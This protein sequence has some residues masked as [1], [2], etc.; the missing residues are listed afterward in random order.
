MKTIEESIRLFTNAAVKVTYED[1]S[2]HIHNLT[3][4]K[5]IK[6]SYQTSLII[7]SF[8]SG[9]TIEESYDDIKNYIDV[10]KEEFALVVSTLL[11]SEFIVHPDN[12]EHKWADEIIKKWSKYGWRGASLYHLLTYDY[13]FLDYK[14]NGRE[15]DK[16]TMS[17]YAKEEKDL[18][19]GKK[20]SN[21]K[22]EVNIDS[23]AKILKKLNMPFKTNYNNLKSEADLEDIKTIM[24]LAFGVLRRRKISLNNDRADLVRKINPSGGARHPS[25]GYLFNLSVKGLTKGVYHYSTISS[26]LDLIAELPCEEEL[27][28][29]FPGPFRSPF[30]PQAFIVITS[31]FERNMYR[32]REPRTFRTIFMDVGHI[33]ENINKISDYIGLN[34]FQ[35]QGIED[36]LVEEV[37]D[38]NHLSEGAIIGIAVGGKNE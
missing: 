17:L 15:I 36:Q 34:S 32:Y 33:V 38:I 8:M 7:I 6:T 23:P 30:K 22:E 11:K 27:M 37:L 28:G 24:G 2:W 3:N 29:M 19:R 20:Y 12:P 1:N 9:S 31:L 4:K 21:I 16:N 13:P 14:E 26:S 35:H 25:E 18:D 10:T 5:T